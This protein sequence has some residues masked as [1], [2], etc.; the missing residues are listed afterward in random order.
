MALS[1]YNC[2]LAGVSIPAGATHLSQSSNVL[3]LMIKACSILY[4]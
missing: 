1:R 2:Y 4:L 3:V